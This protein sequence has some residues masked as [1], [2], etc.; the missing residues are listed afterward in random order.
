M[1]VSPG[2]KKKKCPVRASFIAQSVK[3]PPAMQQVSVQFLGQEDLQ[4]DTDTEGNPLSYTGFTSV[5]CRARGV[6]E[7]PQCIAKR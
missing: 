2:I 6:K 7:M 3:N 4:K 1:T 5:V